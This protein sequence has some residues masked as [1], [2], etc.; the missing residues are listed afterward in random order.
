MF[1][2]L[3]P[4]VYSPGS[5]IPFICT[6]ACSSEHAEERDLWYY[7]SGSVLYSLAIDFRPAGSHWWLKYMT[8]FQGALSFIFKGLFYFTQVVITKEPE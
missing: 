5:E 2:V 7:C 6:S 1:A 3:A 4:G 8:E